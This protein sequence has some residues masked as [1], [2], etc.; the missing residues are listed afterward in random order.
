MNGAAA[1]SLEDTPFPIITFGD[2]DSGAPRLG[3]ALSADDTTAAIEALP[4][5]TIQIVRLWNTRELNT[6]IHRVLLDSRDGERRGFPHEVA[7]ELMFLAKLNVL[8]RAYEA[9]PLLGTT[10]AEACRLIENGDHAA[11]SGAPIDIW[12]VGERPRD[13][14][15]TMPQ[16]THDYRNRQHD[17]KQAALSPALNEAPTIPSSACV[18]LTTARTLRHDKPG[19]SSEVG[20][21]MDQ[22]FFRCIAKEL[23]NLKIPQLVLSDLG[24]TKRCQWL[25]AAISFAKKHSHFPTVV[26]HT[27]PLSAQETQ[28][29]L[30][31]AA[32]LDHLVINLNLASGRWRA[33]AEAIAESDPEYFQH[34]I[35]HLIRSRDD[36]TAKTGH[37]CA[38][39][40]IQID[41]KSV[42]HL[43]DS[44][45]LLGKEAGLE[46][47][48]HVSDGKRG[49]NTGNCHCWSPFIE[50][51]VRTNG[52][53]VS[54]AQD[55]SGFSFVADLKETTFTEAWHGQIF[56]NLRQRV[57]HGEKPGR[58][59]E[60][61]RHRA[62]E[63]AAGQA[64]PKPAALP[65]FPGS[66]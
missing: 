41:H 63:K 12:G 42:F 61:C 34:Q 52:H 57:L 7:K 47:F 28:L 38:I 6:L 62:T 25:P 13:T 1:I 16:A 58:L 35:R 31:M 17:H 56:R 59:C 51:H 44:F 2:T 53:L 23:G 18:D 24:N 30:A 48:R 9:A 45:R 26:L 49:E 37:H 5:L 4:R 19:L 60:I 15:L 21:V 27:D 10:L 65:S 14:S 54:C 22:G 36:I 20:E 8:I 64:A 40:V 50:A 11:L 55:H 39:S 46:P 32:G 3:T 43:S 66:H 33:Q 29:I